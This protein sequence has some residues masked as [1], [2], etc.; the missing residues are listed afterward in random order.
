MGNELHSFIT[1][2]CL[3]ELCCIVDA[4]QLPLTS[5]TFAS[6]YSLSL[7]LFLL[8]RSLSPC[9]SWAVTLLL[10]YFLVFMSSINVKSKPTMPLCRAVKR[11]KQY[12]KNMPIENLVKYPRFHLQLVCNMLGDHANSLLAWFWISLLFIVLCCCCVVVVLCC[13]VLCCVVLCC[14]VLCCCLDRWLL[15]VFV[16]SWVSFICHSVI[17][18]TLV[19]PTLS[20]SHFFLPFSLVCAYAVHEQMNS[21]RIIA[22]FSQHGSDLPP[23]LPAFP[24]LLSVNIVRNVLNLVWVLLLSSSYSINRVLKMA[25]EPIPISNPILNPIQSKFITAFYFNSS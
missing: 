17:L 25:A 18:V 20:F 21:N 1:C 9:N 15:N 22:V 14:V 12:L 10:T 19:S 16:Q 11:W 24:L 7:S 13:V 2:C 4:L 3:I 23:S 6:L 5:V 8:V